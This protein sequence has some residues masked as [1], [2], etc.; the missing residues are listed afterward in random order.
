VP[1]HWADASDSGTIDV[2]DLPPGQH[3]ITID[4]VDGNHQPFPG[5]SKSVTFTVPDTVHSH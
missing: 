3:K 5:Q 1:S 2:K 4:L